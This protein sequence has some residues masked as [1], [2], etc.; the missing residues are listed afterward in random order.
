MKESD[1]SCCECQYERKLRWSEER[2]DGF[3][4][5]TGDRI[6]MINHRKKSPEWCPLQCNRDKED[7]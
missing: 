6:G 2:F 1:I 7:E 3:C 5:C 4:K